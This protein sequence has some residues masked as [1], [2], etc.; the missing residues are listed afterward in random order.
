L[1]GRSIT[2]LFTV[3]FGMNFQQIYLVPFSLRHIFHQ[4]EVRNSSSTRLKTDVDMSADKICIE[5]L[6]M[7]L[8]AY[9]GF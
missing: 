2:F 9:A 6:M 4:V 8:P 1:A 3:A 7:T 5:L